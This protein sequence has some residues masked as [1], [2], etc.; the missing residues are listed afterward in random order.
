MQLHAAAAA[1]AWQALSNIVRQMQ[2]LGLVA[3]VGLFL[4]VVF[5][6]ELH[7]LLQLGHAIHGHRAVASALD[8]PG[9]PIQL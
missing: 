6:S 2:S 7:R 9:S 8:W 5:L 1:A 3:A 4:Q